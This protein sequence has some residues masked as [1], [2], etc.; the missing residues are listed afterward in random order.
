MRFSFLLIV[1]LLFVG[2]TAKPAMATDP[3]ATAAT[4]RRHLPG[5][6]A[7]LMLVSPTTRSAG[8]EL[9]QRL[10]HRCVR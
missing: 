2:L 1:P 5:L 6:D 3:T 8:T 4:F 9:S 7:S 10:R